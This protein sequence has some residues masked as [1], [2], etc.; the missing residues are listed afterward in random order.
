MRFQEEI[1]E[2]EAATTLARIPNRLVERE[3][4]VPRHRD[5][6]SVV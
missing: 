3:G 2:E 5:E 1:E 6:R 4:R